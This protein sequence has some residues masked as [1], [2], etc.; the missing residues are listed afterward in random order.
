MVGNIFKLVSFALKIL[1]VPNDNF[2]SLNLLLIIHVNLFAI[3]KI[4][5][6]KNP[7]PRIEDLVNGRGLALLKLYH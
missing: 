1:V 2:P 5:N 6:L 4:F 3:L 7:Y